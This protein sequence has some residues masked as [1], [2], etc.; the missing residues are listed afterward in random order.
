M[1]NDTTR[2]RCNVHQTICIQIDDDNQPC[3]VSIDGQVINN[4]C[5]LAIN[6]EGD[7]LEDV[8]LTIKV[9]VLADEISLSTRQTREH[10]YPR[11]L[12]KP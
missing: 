8:V 12:D 10:A 7:H 9:R 11:S 3:T 2:S 1:T 4:V 5:G 6:S